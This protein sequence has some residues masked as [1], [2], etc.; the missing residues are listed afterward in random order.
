MTPF[1]SFI[2]LLKRLDFNGAP[3]TLT[4]KN[5]NSYQTPIGGVVTIISRLGIFAFFLVLI[6]NIVNKEKK[7]VYK[8]IHKGANLD[9]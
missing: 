7:V 6:F 9:N 3:I 2:S 4:Y 5:R 1:K 8:S